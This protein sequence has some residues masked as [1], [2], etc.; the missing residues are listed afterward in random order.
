MRRLT[1]L[2]EKHVSDNDTCGSDWHLFVGRQTPAICEAWLVPTNAVRKEGSKQ[3][4]KEGRRE[5]RKE[6][7]KGRVWGLISSHQ[8]CQEGRK[9]ARKEGRDE[10]SSTL[11]QSA[12]KYTVAAHYFSLP[13]NIP[14]SHSLS[15]DYFNCNVYHSFI[16]ISSVLHTHHTQTNIHI[17]THLNIPFNHHPFLTLHSSYTHLTP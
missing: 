2:G 12:L 8:R 13:S 1:Y 11:L 16:I 6:G 4:R 7:R 9:Q 3:G 10:C 17:A 15:A 5:G 14:F